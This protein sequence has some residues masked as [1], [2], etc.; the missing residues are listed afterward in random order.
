MKLECGCGNTD[1]T[2]FSIQENRIVWLHLSIVD[3]R[4]V[5]GDLE[6]EYVEEELLHC[7]ECSETQC[8]SKYREGIEVEVDQK[9]EAK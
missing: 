5:A 3:G 1:P 6:E 9:E 7:T 4:A 2:R 8:L